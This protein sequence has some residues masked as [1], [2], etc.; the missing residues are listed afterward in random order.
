MDKRVADRNLLLGILALQRQDINQEQLIQAF[1]FWISDKQRSIGEIFID[2]GWLTSEQVLDLHGIIDLQIEKVGDQTN[3]IKTLPANDGVLFQLAATTQDT[4]LMQSVGMITGIFT[5]TQNQLEASIGR[6][7]L[8]NIESTDAMATRQQESATDLNLDDSISAIKTLDTTLETRDICETDLT[9]TEV[10]EQKSH[11]RPSGSAEMKVE[12]RYETAFEFLPKI[13][14]LAEGAMGAVFRAEDREFGRRV[15]LK[16]VKNNRRVQQNESIQSS[17]FLEGEVTG[18][19]DHPGVL[20]MYG[21][22]RTPDGL[23]FY[24][25]KF[26]G[27]PKFTKLIDD[28]HEAEARPGRDPGQS[29]QELRH[30]LNHL[31]SACLTIQYAHDNGVLHCDIKPDNIMT[32]EYGET[33]VVDWGLALLV[34]PMQDGVLTQQTGTGTTIHPVSP[35]RGESRAALHRDQGGS[36]D[37]IGGSPAYMSPE[38]HQCT[39][40]R[41][42]TEMT[43]ACDIFSL[44]AT[45]YQIITGVV[46]VNAVTEEGYPRRFARMRLA[47]YINPRTLKPGLSKSLEAIC[48][49]AIAKDPGDRYESAKA[50]ADDLER[51]QAGEPVSAYPENWQ[52][53]SIRWARRNR[54]TVVAIAATLFVVTFFSLITAGLLGRKNV[55]L[56]Q[57]N[58][59]IDQQLNELGRQNSEIQRQNVEIGRER[60]RAEEQALIAEANEKL[61]ERRERMAVEAVREYADAVSENEQLK[62]RPE[63]EE[64]R[65]NLLKSPI[66]FFR[67]LNDDFRSSNDT[68][69][70]S[71]LS[72]SQGLFELAHLTDSIGNRVDARDSYF[73]SVKLLRELSRKQPENATYRIELGKS[74]TNLGLAESFMGNQQAGR[75]NQQAAIEEFEKLVKASP[76]DAGLISALAGALNSLGN[77]E[78]E[79]GNLVAAR[80]NYNRAIFLRED[81]SKSN[82]ENTDVKSSLARV[83][84]NLSVL[85]KNAG[86]AEAA[87]SNY[88][89]AIA[90][91]DSIV[92][93]S[94]RR[95]EYRNDLAISLINLATLESASG[96]SEA[97][98]EHLNRANE[99]FQMILKDNPTM[100]Q[101]QLRRA[102]VL[103]QLGIIDAGS[104]KPAE[105][106]SSFSQAIDMLE[107]LIKANPASTEFRRG[108]AFAMNNLGNLEKAT[109]NPATARVYYARSIE[110]YELL[111]KTSPTVVEFQNS[112]AAALNNI[113]GVESSVEAALASY[114]RA[115]EIRE[116]IISKNP[117]IPDNLS[118]LAGTYNNIAIIAPDVEK[119][120]EMLTKSID[121]QTRALRIN[122]SNPQYIRQ[123]IRHLVNYFD[124]LPALG[125]ADSFDTALAR[126]NSLNEQFPQYAQILASLLPRLNASRA[127]LTASLANRNADEYKKSLEKAQDALKSGPEI[128]MAIRAVGTAQFRSGQFADA[129][130]NLEKSLLLFKM[131]NGGKEQLT[132]IAILAMT[133]WQLNRKSEAS[134]L[135]NRLAELMHQP[136]NKLEARLFDE[137]SSMIKTD[138]KPK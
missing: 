34:G 46:P 12:F 1:R 81:L 103:V 96:K 124:L 110:N 48:L 136:R 33:Y 131:M 118:D 105:S 40:D 123:L 104:G 9:N 57:K 102:A 47:D 11:S 76:K 10:P 19:L 50:L 97:A 23:P 80:D 72:L 119:S 83:L 98:R 130:M 28:Y 77:L 4:D 84:N 127:F 94:P 114:T 86:N 69:P 128:P 126:L 21:L 91:S 115:I 27:S 64:L 32:G 58:N 66:E 135:F 95:I 85:E 20:P 63:L 37:Y 41:K 75:Q 106:R 78:R 24:A 133:Y 120:V 18:R 5:H 60:N 54:T 44:G 129:A 88:N 90:I 121:L 25:M 137:A 26:I 117:D 8:I 134:T 99:T 71:L 113:A 14:Y 82:P 13:D 35:R 100:T 43:P 51:W 62:N 108:L 59:L 2:K 107:S 74:L 22:G 52:E 17:F 122:P 93:L 125:D 6:Q 7:T 73:E 29:N 36:R 101:F 112:L 38:H 53:R 70:E 67:R 111:V 132:D 87:R 31:R 56:A 45:L 16:Q 109:G 15:A 65:K 55:E 30:L 68:R 39:A 61:A 116:S 89:R 79:S 42:L 3:L 92:A 138:G 49:K